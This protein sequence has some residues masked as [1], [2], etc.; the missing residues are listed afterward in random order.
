MPKL[1]S[2]A[3]SKTPAKASAR[4]TDSGAA[5]VKSVR[6]DAPSLKM[7]HT[8][9][10]AAAMPYNPT[11]ASEHGLTCGL[12]PPPGSTVTPVS[13]LPAS[14]I[15]IISFAMK[16]SP[17]VYSCNIFNITIR[18]HFFPVYFC[19]FAK[20]YSFLTDLFRPVFFFFN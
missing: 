9:A 5:K 6:D 1:D 17:C 16:S 2:S 3:P 14:S 20:F 19:T 4:A 8:D 11:K 12:N 18:D 13:H 15:A 7:A 10:L